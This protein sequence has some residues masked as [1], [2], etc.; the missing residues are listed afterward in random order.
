VGFAFGP[1]GTGW[2][3]ANVA[4]R[5]NSRFATAAQDAVARAASM[6][7]SYGWC[8]G[9]AGLAVAQA[10]AAPDLDHLDRVARQLA[11]RPVL[12]DLSLC[13]GELG[14]AEA[15]TVLAAQVPASAV[16]RRRA[17]LVLDAIDRYGPTCGTPGAV[18]SPGLFN[19]L[20]G[21]G[22]GLLRLGFADLVPSVLLLQP[23]F[24]A[25]G[26]TQDDNTET[27]RRDW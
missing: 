13:H 15:L 14:I 1:A 25:E 8:S 2:A 7:A 9:L 16:A 4:T 22:Y 20:A 24:A 21:I 17:G 5:D 19:G 11:D 12:R 6:P 26:N 3:L 27:R 23:R 10:A 18:S